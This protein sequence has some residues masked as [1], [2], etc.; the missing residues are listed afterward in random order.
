MTFMKIAGKPID[1]LTRCEHYHTPLD[2]IAILFPCCNEY[3]PCY[4]CHEETA[5]H[6]ATRWPKDK[7]DTKAILCGN[8]KQE[9]TIYE[10]FQSNHHCPNC[11]ADFNPKCANHYTLYFDM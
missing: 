5:N 6:L 11:K 7:R 4:E 3:Y 2:I 8:C 10:Y 1:E 9:L